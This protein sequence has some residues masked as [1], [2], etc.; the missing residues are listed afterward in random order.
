VKV[1]ASGFSGAACTTP[2][3]IQVERPGES[4]FTT[5]TLT[6]GCYVDPLPVQGTYTFQAVDCHGCT[7]QA[8]LSVCVTSPSIGA[9]TLTSNPCSGLAVFTPGTVAGGTGPFT[10]AWYL[11][12]S[13]TPAG[14]DATFTYHPTVNAASGLDTSCHSLVVTVTDANGCTATSSPITFSQCVNTTTGC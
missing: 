12:G 1:S 7:R 10:Y 6:G 8:T 13:T 3:T 11:D 14:T 5:V 9:T 2:L 4:T